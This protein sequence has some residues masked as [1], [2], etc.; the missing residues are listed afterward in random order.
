MQF[1]DALT[2][3]FEYTVS[4]KRKRRETS[5]VCLSLGN[6]QVPVQDNGCVDSI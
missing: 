4:I 6:I 3:N 5:L 2:H 1:L